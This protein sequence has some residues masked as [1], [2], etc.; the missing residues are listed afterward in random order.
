MLPFTNANHCMQGPQLHLRR[1]EHAKSIDGRPFQYD[2]SWG[3]GCRCG[4]SV[5]ISC[6][7]RWSLGGSIDPGP[8]L[9]QS[10]FTHHRRWWCFYP[11]P[12][13]RLSCVFTVHE[14]VQHSCVALSLPGPARRWAGCRSSDRRDS[15]V[16]VQVA[17]CTLRWAVMAGVECC[18]LFLRQMTIGRLAE[19]GTGV[20]NVRGGITCHSNR[21]F[22]PKT[23]P[24]GTVTC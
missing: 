7:V 5:L 21:S 17:A 6:F 15:P 23:V 1:S 10:Q 14:C 12:R 8:C 2:E 3:P 4:E 18:S 13:F 22:T 9:W 19:T 20:Y 11:S 16:V 24:P